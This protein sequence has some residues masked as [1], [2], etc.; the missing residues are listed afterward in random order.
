MIRASSLN[1]AQHCPG[2]PSLAA[3]T[4]PSADTDAAMSAGTLVHAYIEAAISCNMDRRAADERVPIPFDLAS[5]LDDAWPT[6][7]DL[8]RS[9]HDIRCEVSHSTATLSGR[10]DVVAVNQDGE[11]VVVDW[12]WGQGQRMILPRIAEDLQMRA[13]AA[14]FSASRALRVRLCDGEIDTLDLSPLDHDDLFRRVRIIDEATKAGELRTGVHCEHCW[15]R[16]SCDAWRAASESVTTMLAPSQSST[17]APLTR[18]QATRWALSRQAVKQRC[19]DL[20]DA[21]RDYLES[22]GE[23]EA[24]GK[25]LRITEYSVD[26]IDEH[27]ALFSRLHYSVAGAAAL[28]VSLSKAGIATALAAV[29]MTKKE[30]AAWI[31][32]ARADGLIATRKQ[33]RMAWK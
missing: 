22:G 15:A 20:D 31:D 19:A 26:T 14:L 5:E 23:V 12:K 21:L 27:A 8:I 6:V 25:T 17:I 24:G 10:A 29:G 7:E 4:R 1:Q 18:D 13:Y 11:R 30:I 32:A 16:V 9:L 3:K 28:G 2:F 33:K